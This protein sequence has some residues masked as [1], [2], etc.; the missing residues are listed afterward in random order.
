MSVETIVHSLEIAAERAGDIA[1]AIYEAY[2]ARCPGSN[3]LMRYVDQYMRGRMLNSVF[4]L[5]MN[6]ETSDQ[7]TYLRFEA[8]NHMS[9]GVLPHMYENLITAVRDTVRDACGND[10]T[11]A[12]ATA[13]N[14]RGDGILQKIRFFLEQAATNP[15]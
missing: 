4:E 7:L 14:S 11:P 12:M 9:F 5:L 3:E 15:V 10:W 6:E 8:K 1:P 13:W 2:F